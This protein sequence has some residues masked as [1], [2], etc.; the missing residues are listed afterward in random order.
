MKADA[1]G[2]RLAHPLE[3]VEQRQRWGR[4][5]FV[6]VAILALTGIFTCCC[7]TPMIWDG[8]YQFCF[9]LIKQRPYFY[10][11]R[12]HSYVLWLPLVWL[13]H[14]TDNLTIL[15]FAY[16]LPFTLAPAFSV[17]ASWWIVRERS[18]GL[19]LWAIFGVAASPLPGQIF[20]INDSIFQQHMFWP[21]YLAVL[22]PLRWPQVIFVSL[23]AVFQ[24]SHQIGLL[25][26][27]GGAGAA[28]LLAARDQE[29][30]RELLIKA[31]ILLPL[32][33][34]ALWKIFHFPDSYAEREFTRE[35]IHESWQY[36]VEGYPLRGVLFMCGAGA[37]VILPRVLRGSWLRKAW[38]VLSGMAILCLLGA[39]VNWT[40]WA[41]DSH[42]WS[43]AANY[44][45]WVVPLTV[46]FYL[47]AFL[48]R[49]LAIGRVPAEKGARIEPFVGVWVATTFALILSI[50]SVVWMQLT[51]RLMRDVDPYPK[52]IV[53][54][55]HIS[56]TRDTP[57]YHWGTT[58]Y[59]F[60]L[61]GRAPKRLVLDPDDSDATKQ[62]EMLN[63]IPPKIPLSWFTPISP[64]PG[65]AGWFDFRPMLFEIHHEK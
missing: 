61:E 21:V 58:P 17:V 18:P 42:K 10:L 34:V 44:R 53:P 39:S 64:I 35:R 45:R 14:F 20:I 65:P 41:L 29:N 8:A 33:L 22:V 52:A 1:A 19:L 40:I 62:I 54:F 23:L 46:P 36:G 12:I 13:S 37:A 2:I 43:T 48:D 4:V 28:L 3:I 47:L 6:C 11:T 27:A 59:V 63:Q 38:P 24:F 56:W 31:G 30:R 32:A 55:S 25:L 49:W 7:D 50:Q 9:S 57:L 5:T 51:R 26:L 15:K 16:G 60:V